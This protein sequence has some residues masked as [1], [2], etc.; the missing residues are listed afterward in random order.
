MDPSAEEGGGRPT[1]V[2]HD[3]A[4]APRVTVPQ[5]RGPAAAATGPSPAGPGPAPRRR[6][7][8]VAV[9]A[10]VSGLVAA[11]PVTLVLGPL[12][13]IRVGRSGARGRALAVTGLVLAGLWTVAGAV[14]AAA[15]ITRPPPPPPVTLP[16]VFSLRAGQCLDSDAN[17][18]SG[19]QVLSCGQAH[20]AEVFATFRVAG[21]RY[22]GAAALQQ[23]A[24]KGCV[25]RLA[26][27]LN[28]ELPAT[29]LAQSFVYP[30]PGAWSAGERTVVCTVRGTSGPLVGSVRAA[31]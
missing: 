16:H 22:P 24:R 11:I 25:S 31:P 30:G 17:G 3:P 10:L 20:D 1:A 23:R 14:V 9:A 8:R 28:P 26:G 21:S 7:D 27:Y 5:Q 18:M 12:A 2:A 4:A 19:V 13:L 6:T 29:S 15:I